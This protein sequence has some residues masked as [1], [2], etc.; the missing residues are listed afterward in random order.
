MKCN[1]HLQRPQTRGRLQ[2]NEKKKKQCAVFFPFSKVQD[3]LFSPWNLIEKKMQND[4]RNEFENDFTLFLWMDLSPL[5]WK[6]MF[7][8]PPPSSLFHLPEHSGMERKKENPPPTTNSWPEFQIANQLLLLLSHCFFLFL[9]SFWAKWRIDR[10]S[11]FLSRNYIYGSGLIH[12]EQCPPWRRKKLRNY[13]FASKKGPMY[14]KK[15]KFPVFGGGELQNSGLVPQIKPPPLLLQI[16]SLPRC[17]KGTFRSILF[18]AERTGKRK[19][20]FSSRKA[21]ISDVSVLEMRYFKG[22][23]HD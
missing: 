3:K 12:E 7:A 13:F 14:V 6:L 15:K 22:R 17:P 19:K 20:R 18:P 23:L 2:Q 16:F 4:R 5:S 8:P 11:F 10:G 9:I 1:F 21:G